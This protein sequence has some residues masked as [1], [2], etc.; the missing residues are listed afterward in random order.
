ME[1]RKEDDS[2]KNLRSE[3]KERAE[4]ITP[5]LPEEGAGAERVTNDPSGKKESWQ[6]RLNEEL[7]AGHE[8]KDFTD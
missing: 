7:G 5:P 1:P 8:E 3:N 4:D 2:P 6:H